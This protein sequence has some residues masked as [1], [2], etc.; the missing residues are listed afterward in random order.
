MLK[1]EDIRTEYLH[2][3]KVRFKNTII[4][5]AAIDQKTNA[6]I[7][8]KLWELS[9]VAVIMFSFAAVLLALWVADYS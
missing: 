7:L 1:V 3:S 5:W 9:V 4:F 6:K 2:L 8:K